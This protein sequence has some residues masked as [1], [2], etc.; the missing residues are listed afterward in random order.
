VSKLQTRDKLRQ[1]RAELEM[2]ECTFKPAVPKHHPSDHMVRNRSEE[3]IFDRL[4]RTQ[5]VGKQD[6][7]Q[8]QQ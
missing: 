6:W 8:L 1:L 2:V 4:H 3:H 7:Q 5:L